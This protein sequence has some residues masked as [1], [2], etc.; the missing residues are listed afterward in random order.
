MHSSASSEHM[1]IAS[2]CV[3]QFRLSSELCA[4]IGE[5]V[6]AV[7]AQ[8]N[9]ANVPSSSYADASIRF[10]LQGTNVGVS[11]LQH[12]GLPTTVTRWRMTFAAW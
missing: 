1:N 9:P 5:F 4:G 10:R 8:A 3:I 12:N 6:Y 11:E 2:S 7:M